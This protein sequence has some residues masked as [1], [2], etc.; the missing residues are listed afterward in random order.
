MNTILHVCQFLAMVGLVKDSPTS[1]K[2]GRGSENLPLGI[3]VTEEISLADVAVV[4]NATSSVSVCLTGVGEGG[5]RNVGFDVD[6]YGTLC[7]ICS[8]L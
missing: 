3:A 2:G 4:R 8:C 6:L 1:I 5:G 7:C